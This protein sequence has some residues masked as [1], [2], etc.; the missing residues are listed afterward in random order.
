[1]LNLALF[2]LILLTNWL[3]K[4]NLIIMKYEPGCSGSK[5]YERDVPD[6]QYLPMNMDQKCFF[7]FLINS[8][9]IRG[10]MKELSWKIDFGKNKIGVLAL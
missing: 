9:S 7:Y 10:V 8:S 6:L 2:F 5:R 3:H 1:M 4:L